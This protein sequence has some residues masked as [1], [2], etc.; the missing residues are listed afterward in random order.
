[1]AENNWLVNPR[2]FPLEKWSALRII[3]A[4]FWDKICYVASERKGFLTY[5]TVLWREDWYLK[6]EQHLLLAG[7]RIFWNGHFLRTDLILSY[8][9]KQIYLLVESLQLSSS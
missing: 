9:W 2:T 4:K 6:R 7:T 8:S 3:S 1:M 5:L